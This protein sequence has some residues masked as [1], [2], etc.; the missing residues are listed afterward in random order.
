MHT[1]NTY[2]YI[3]NT[4]KIRT[5]NVGRGSGSGKLCRISLGFGTNFIVIST[6]VHSC[7]PPE[8]KSPK[9]LGQIQAI[10]PYCGQ[11]CLRRIH[12]EEKQQYEIVQNME[13]L[14][15]FNLEN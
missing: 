11:F 6:V 8:A 4:Q 15:E 13:N 2:K 3:K 10:S 12:N 1:K 9:Y 7:A 14:L 5:K